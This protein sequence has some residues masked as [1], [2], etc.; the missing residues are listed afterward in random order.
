MLQYKGTHIYEKLFSI[1][2]KIER[3]LPNNSLK[4][5]IKEQ[6]FFSVI[7]PF[8]THI[9]SEIMEI[10]FSCLRESYTIDS[11]YKTPGNK[12]KFR[13]V[14][15]YHAVRF[16]GDWYVIGYCHFRKEIRTFSMS[17][18][19]DAKK[20]LNKF[21]LPINF[22]YESFLFNNFG[23]TTGEKI[24]DVK[25]KFKKSVSD[26]INERIWHES[27]IISICED[28]SLVLNI[29]VSNLLD[30]K[31]WILSWGEMA[32]VI[33]PTALADDIHDIAL[34]LVHM[35]SKYCAHLNEFY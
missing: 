9:S 6:S 33:E 23:L 27:Q 29:K 25:I 10:I 4:I 16:E 2:D 22:D 18:I 21:I 3:C 24:I 12:P 34:K 26:Y 31:K 8:S 30:L 32:Q 35:Y 13:Q 5:P 19:I 11:Q 20:G 14:D 28:G 15:P 17:R 1:F 7:P